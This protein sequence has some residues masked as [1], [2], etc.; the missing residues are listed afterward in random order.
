M[1]YSL[2]FLKRFSQL[3]G[4]LLICVLFYSV[5]VSIAYRDIDPEHLA[6]KYSYRNL[7][8]A[9]VDGVSLAFQEDGDAGSP[10]ILLLH[11]HYFSMRMWDD[12]IGPLAKTYRVIRFD[13]TSHGLTGPDP[14]DDYSMARS[15]QLLTG[16][17]DHLDVDQVSLV[18]S[19]LGG[20]M[21]FTFAANNPDRVN[22]LVLMNSGGLKRKDA[23][24]GNIPAWVDYVFYLL[25]RTAYRALLKWMIIDDS[26]VTTQMVEEFHDMFRR[27][28]NRIA[29]LN[30]LRSFKLGDADSLLPMVT[31]PTL[32][33]W[34]RENPQLDF[35]TA[36]RFKQKLINTDTRVTIYDDIGHV[37]PLEMPQTGVVDLMKFL[38]ADITDK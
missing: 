31:A 14:K 21:A 4:I 37:I 24:S 20:N 30:R 17:L 29:E 26:L 10:V 3:I 7:Q 1:N 36:I 33:M 27:N 28:G 16:L 35:S 13:M 2:I 8:T 25:P 32:V 12:W 38:S 11:S 34:G 19:S 5:Y 15:Q 22:K 18:G 23:R 9:L 6:S